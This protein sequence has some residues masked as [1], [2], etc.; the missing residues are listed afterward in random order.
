MPVLLVIMCLNYGTC[1][2]GTTN[3]NCN[4]FKMCRTPVYDMPL[5]QWQQQW[6]LH[7]LQQQSPG[8]QHNGYL[9]TCI[10]H[11][12]HK[13]SVDVILAVWIGIM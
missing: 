2:V 8:E 9:L 13:L 12:H 3:S 10:G 1:V 6:W 7:P 4:C 5:Q 11:G